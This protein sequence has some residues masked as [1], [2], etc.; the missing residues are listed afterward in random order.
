MVDTLQFT[1]AISRI[2]VLE[3]RLLDKS[4]IDK[5]LEANSYDD[6]FKVLLDSEYGGAIKSVGNNED[7]EKILNYELSR[8]YK[9][10]YEMSPKSELVDLMSMKYDYHNIKVLLKG[11]FLK[12]DLSH[13][14]LNI[15]RL[16]IKSLQNS[17]ESS[18]FSDYNKIRRLAI[19]QSIEDF[20]AEKDPQ[21]IDIILDKYMFEEM[22]LTSKSLKYNFITKYV[23]TL[24]DLNNIKILLRV[25]KQG[26]SIEFLKLVMIDGGAIDT[27]KL[28][29][30]FNAEAENLADILRYTDYFNGL[31]LGIEDYTKKGSICL[32][33]K[34]IDNFIMDM[35]KN[36]KMVPFGM[37]SIIAYIYAKETETQI[38]R[39]ILVGK[40]NDIAKGVI[41]ER[42]RD[43]YV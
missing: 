4:K 7:Y 17:I 38:I 33:E 6:A 3:T 39:I 37:E 9:E 32:L 42:L 22:L 43:I 25:K 20:N 5:M 8:V 30:L 19:E 24:I 27:F 29:D 26:K 31:A 2:R 13:I 23:K 34:L 11:V 36:A 41:M 35:M 28:L 14:L 40:Q 16:D 21:R 12:K 18:D 15:G 10:L 1:Q